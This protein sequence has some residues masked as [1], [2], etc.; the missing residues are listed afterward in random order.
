M[1]KSRRDKWQK[2]DRFL[3]L[4]TNYCQ[5]GHFLSTIYHFGQFSINILS[6]ITSWFGH[7]L[8]I[9]P[10]FPCSASFALS[11]V[12]NIPRLGATAFQTKN[13]PPL[14]SYTLPW[15]KIT[16]NTTPPPFFPIGQWDLCFIRENRIGFHCQSSPKHIT[17]LLASIYT[18]DCLLLSHGVLCSKILSVSGLPTLTA[19]WSLNGMRP[20]Y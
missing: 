9:R 16:I 4:W 18:H 10:L 13:L 3:S 2:I 20:T 1:S 7:V 19:P 8:S 5:F 15:W 17:W 6:F 11:L 12:V 14:D